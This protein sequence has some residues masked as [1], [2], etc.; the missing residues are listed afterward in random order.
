MPRKCPHFI[1]LLRRSLIYGKLAQAERNAKKMPAFY[2]F[3]EAQPNSRV[4]P[5]GPLRNLSN[6]PKEGM[7][8]QENQ[9][10][11]R[12]TTAQSLM[13]PVAEEKPQPIL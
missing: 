6:K 4:E 8:R 7:L 5:N 10:A 12:G 9:G 3:A 13:V 11:Q 2:C 1:A